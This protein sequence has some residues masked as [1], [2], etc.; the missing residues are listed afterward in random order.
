MNRTYGFLVMDVKAVMDQSGFLLLADHFV[1]FYSLPLSYR[2]FSS[3]TLVEYF[4]EDIF[5]FS[6][7]SS[8]LASS[9]C[10]SL[11]SIA[12]SIL[13]ISFCRSASWS[14]EASGAERV[15]ALLNHGPEVLNLVLGVGQIFW[16]GADQLLVKVVKKWAQ[17]V[18]WVWVIGHHDIIQTCVCDLC[19]FSSRSR[20]IIIRG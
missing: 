2:G 14:F 12:D 10:R 16:E 7:S 15:L 6:S 19:R 3:L 18:Q 5:V 4:F 17:H 11:S 13:E 9:I 8:C 20:V 1:F